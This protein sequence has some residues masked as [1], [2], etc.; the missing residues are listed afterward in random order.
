MRIH[1]N[2]GISANGKEGL[3]KAG[4]NVS[5]NSV[6]QAEL[7]AYLN[8]EKADV[9]LVRSA[10]KVPKELIDACPRIRLIGRGGVGLDNI[11]VAHARSKGVLVINTPGASS[12]SVAEMV[13][14]HLSGLM[15]G[16]HQSNRLMPATGATG[17]KELK[18]RFGKGRELRGSTLGIIGF[19]RIGQW[20]A[21]YAIG[22]GMEVIYTDHTCT[23]GSIEVTLGGASVAIP[24]ERV[25]MEE[26][27]ARADAISIHVPKQP[28]GAPVLGAAE[29]VKVRPGTFI[30]N[31]A[32]G[33]SVDEDALLAALS[34]GRVAGAALDVFVGEP[35]PRADLLA[36][37]GL[38]LSPHIG[39]ATVEAQARIGDELAEQI[40]AWSKASVSQG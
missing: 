37:E 8:E 32:R 12:I 39:A 3:E 18:K 7:I 1:A 30:V 31:T 14:A 33:G 10:T 5:T 23:I 40:I 16:L 2:D 29:L 35:E 22:C 20:T 24:V 19:G 21:R 4:F 17:F 38:S 13:L 36:A 25:T 9:L 26:L 27:L 15:R 11:D 28:D 34:D 6:P